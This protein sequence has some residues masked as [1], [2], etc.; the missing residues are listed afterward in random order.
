V[1]EDVAVAVALLEIGVP[2][3]EE[4]GGKRVE[5]RDII[6]ARTEPAGRLGS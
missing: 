2:E 3:W 1:V 4:L 5:D 6:R